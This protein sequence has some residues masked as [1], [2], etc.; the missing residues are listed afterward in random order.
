M[1]ERTNHQ[2]YPLAP[3]KAHP[4]S[5][6]ESNNLSSDELRR[7]KRI[8]LAIY[9]VAFAVFQVIV[10]TAFALTI[11]KVK[12]PKV[13]LGTVAL[14]NVNT[15]NQ[16][17]DISFTTQVRIKNTNFGPYKYD[18]TN[19]TFTYQ[20]EAVGQ[21]NIPKSKAG[22]RSTK[23]VSVTVNVNSNALPSTSNLGS[24][25]G[26][27]VLTLSSHAKLSGK[28]ELMFVMKKKKSAEMSCTM[29]INVSTKAVQDLTCE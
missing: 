29:S 18:A 4:R 10:I 13:R 6:E 15:S 26:S 2:D 27:G 22:M 21:V 7:K 9:I 28:V 19:A 14:S 11:M 20:G 12:T 23:K 16:S 3:A 24:D 17:F 1:A 5:D 25:L 8:K